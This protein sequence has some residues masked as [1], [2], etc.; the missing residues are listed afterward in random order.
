MGTWSGLM[1]TWSGHIKVFPKPQ[2]VR[3]DRLRSERE[4][5]LALLNYFLNHKMS[6]QTGFARIENVVWLY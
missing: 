3:A 5:G 2:N 1:G 4:R 6:E